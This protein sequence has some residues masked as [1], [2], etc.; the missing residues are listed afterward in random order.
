V[1]TLAASC[2]DLADNT[3]SAEYDVQV[4][5]GAPST[6]IVSPTSTTY[7]QGDS[8]LADYACTDTV[9]GIATCVGPVADGDPIDTSTLGPISFTV[10]ATDVA[11]NTVEETVEYTVVE[12]DLQGPVAAP[13]QSPPANGAGWSDSPVTVTWNW[14]DSGSGIDA[15][16][17]TATSTSS[18]AGEQTLTATCADRE[19]NATTANYA[20]RVDE[21]DP[22]ITIDAPQATTYIQGAAVAANYTCT[23]TVSGITSCVGP[24]P[25]GDPI[26]TSTLGPASFTVTATDVASN[27]LEATVEYT[28]VAGDTGGPIASPTQAPPANA[29]GWNDSPAT[30]TWNW[31]DPSGIDAASCPETSTSRGEGAITLTASCTDRLGNASAST[32]VVRVD[33]TAPVITIRTPASTY[34]QGQVVIADYECRDTTSGIATCAG[35]VADGVAFDTA[36]L[37]ERTFTVTA[38]DR[39]GNADTA[40]HHYVVVAYL[41]ATGQTSGAIAW[42]A[43]LLLA[44]GVVLVRVG[45][46]PAP[47]TRGSAQRAR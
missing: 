1:Q 25:D 5:T 16:N 34:V 28:V 22:T 32:F 7:V 23:D 42:I 4:D 21:S 3:V 10:T 40:V 35:T 15:A 20:V 44:T 36:T 37:G 33:T 12:R 46:A 6:T 13:T 2:A 43:V 17:C 45:R 29:A 14:S 31:N 19:G 47:R 9:S 38:V 30:V 41:P 11:G 26:D 24:V 27:T 39:A 18:G 8:V